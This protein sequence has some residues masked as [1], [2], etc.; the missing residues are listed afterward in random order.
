MSRKNKQIIIAGS[1]GG[2]GSAITKK[3]NKNNWDV[4]ELSRKKSTEK[5]TL[6]RYV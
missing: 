1:N 4:I 2:V 5:D 6:H 3:F